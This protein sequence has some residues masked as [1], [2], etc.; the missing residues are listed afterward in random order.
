MVL[1]YY[2]EDPSQAEQKGVLFRPAQIYVNSEESI[3]YLLDIGDNK[4]KIYSL[5]NGMHIRDVGH[6]TG[7]GPGEFLKPS[8]FTVYSEEEIIVS[9]KISRR[10]TH[11]NSNGEVVDAYNIP[12]LLGSVEVIDPETFLI[13]PYGKDYDF[14]GVY[15]T[16]H[17]AFVNSFGK[18]YQDDRLLVA[19]NGTL[20]GN[21]QDAIF[22]VLWYS[23]HVVSLGFD[24]SLRFFRKSVE[25]LAFPEFLKASVQGTSRS[26]YSIDRTTTRGFHHIVNVWEEELFVNRIDTRNLFGSKYIGIVDVYSTIDG[27]YLYSIYWPTTDCGIFSLQIDMYIRIVS[28]K[29]SSNG[30]E[31][32]GHLQSNCR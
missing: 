31:P 29:A 15:S 6:G 13:I 32:L 28:V 14:Y 7:E 22:H 10:L 12:S 9:D 5:E 1:G 17:Q 11:F 24:G 27:D 16:R 3:L 19:I 21:R 25:N 30:K 2:P 23:G 4:I 26:A 20:S 8:N 18:Y